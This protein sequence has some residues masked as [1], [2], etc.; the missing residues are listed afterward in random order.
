[1]ENWI[2]Q[3]LV[4]RKRFFWFGFCCFFFFFVLGW[5]KKY[6]RGWK[7]DDISIPASSPFTDVG[8]L[9]CHDKF[10]CAGVNGMSW[11][12]TCANFCCFEAKFLQQFFRLIR[13]WMEILLRSLDDRNCFF[14]KTR[15]EGVCCW[16]CDDVNFPVVF[17]LP[18]LAGM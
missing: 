5:K 18:L 16:W 13:F 2:L 6:F 14:I 15:S 10:G 4:Y 8:E 17:P 7:I 9:L 3:F 12:F 1:M 11:F